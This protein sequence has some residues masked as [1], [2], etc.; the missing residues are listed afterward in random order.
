MNA[1]S[2]LTVVAVALLKP[3]KPDWRAGPPEW[4]VNVT[5]RSSHEWHLHGGVVNVGESRRAGAARET[6]EETGVMVHAGGLRRVGVYDTTPMELTL[7]AAQAPNGC[8]PRV[9]EPDKALVHT[10]V[11]IEKLHVLKPALASLAWCQD[12]LLAFFMNGGFAT[13][14]LYASH[15]D[16]ALKPPALKGELAESLIAPLFREIRTKLM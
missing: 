14:A 6:F 9:I 10:W 15:D 4:F 5:M 13:P 16:V 11:S 3:G 1:D 7:Y 12:A 2:K 8:A